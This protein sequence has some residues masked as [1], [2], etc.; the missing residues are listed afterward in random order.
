[1]KLLD[2]NIIA[3]DII[4]NNIQKKHAWNDPPD[5]AATHVEELYS[6]TSH[7]L[8]AKFSEQIKHDFTACY[9]EMY[10]AAALMERSSFEITHPSDEGA[11]FFVKNL[12][13]WLEV[14]A[15]TNGVEGN[16]NTIPK[17]K[18]NVVQSYP[19]KQVILRLSNAFYTKANKLR[20]D[21]K[22]GLICKD[23]PIILCISGGGLIENI[24]MHAEGGYPVITK[25]VLP[26]GDMMFWLN[27]E[28]H[29]LVS[30]EYKYREGVNKNTTNGESMISTDFFLNEEYNHISAVI[31]SWANAANPINRD[32]WGCD[33]YTVHNPSAINKL[34]SGI[35]R[36]GTEYP[37]TMNAE[38]FTMEPSISHEKS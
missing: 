21:I 22:K 35:I 6:V 17:Q 38:S 5:L 30:N 16:P 14:V 36:C 31:Y 15:A 13:C 3:P 37:V 27:R 1:M 10:F 28:T 32:R 18:M 12:N 4:Y 2:P 7:L 25:A 19:E 24:P 26:V 29:K 11:D 20:N 23:Q 34:P 33:F 8:D 9:S